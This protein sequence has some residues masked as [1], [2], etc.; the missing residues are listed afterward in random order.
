MRIDSRGPMSLH[1][2]YKSLLA[3]G[4]ELQDEMLT[5]RECIAAFSSAHNAL[6]DIEKIVH[7]VSGRPE[8]EMMLLA[9]RELQFGLLSASV[10]HYR[11]ANISS[12]LFM[13]MMFGAIQFS[14]YEIKLRRWKINSQDLVWSS[15]VDKENG[16][17]SN[18]FISAFSPDFAEY[19]REFLLIADSVYRECSEYV[20][21]NINT[22]SEF[23]APLKLDKHQLISW[24]DR[25][26]SILVVTVFLFI[27]RY[28]Y[29]VDFKKY[30][31][32]EH[33]IL[34]TLGDNQAVQ[35][36]LAS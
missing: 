19:G 7:V 1:E 5:D 29:T 14:A 34:D 8:S 33:I 16:V 11:H 12:R 36:L 13:E 4:I 17:F 15:F 23:D 6:N 32:V 20:H 3:K 21:G 25:V 27:S 30:P 9:I 35:T 18:S 2:H 22:H 28:S 10:A 31:E 26:K 24:T